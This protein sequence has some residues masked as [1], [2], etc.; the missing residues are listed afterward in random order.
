MAFAPAAR[1][2]QGGRKDAQAAF[3][4]R[5]GEIGKDT[6]NLLDQLLKQCD[7]R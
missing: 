4:E 3:V 6:E 7:A 5:L 2:S 1:P